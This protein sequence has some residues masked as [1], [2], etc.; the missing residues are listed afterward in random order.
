MRNGEDE[1]GMT[2]VE[3]QKRAPPAAARPQTAVVGEK[4]R[5]DK[6]TFLDTDFPVRIIS[7]EKAGERE[8]ILYKTREKS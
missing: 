2:D 1:G 5:K 6:K 3:E 4:K 8:A 7:R